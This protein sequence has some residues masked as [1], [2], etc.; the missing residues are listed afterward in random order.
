MV[1]CVVGPTASGKTGLAIGLAELFGGEVVSCDSMQIYRGMDIGTAKPTMS[2]RRGIPHH[3]LDIVEPSE[4]FSAARYAEE[5]SA[6]VD[7]IL[8]R[9]RLPVIAGG[10][11]LYLNALL[12]GLHPAAG[13]PELR[14]EIEAR[15]EIYAE[16][17][18]VDPAAAARLHPNDR[19]RIVR[20]LEVY[21]GSGETISERHEISRLEPPRYKSLTIGIKVER[22]ELYARI[23]ER[24]DKMLAEGLRDELKA[25]EERVPPPCHTAAQAIGYKEHGDAETIKMNT[26]RYAKRQM[27][28]FN[29]MP[30][31]HWV[32][33]ENILEQATR[34]AEKY[35]LHKV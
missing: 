31:V 6:C 24:V 1:L 28:W 16:L 3:M 14:R 23:D 12:Y 30:D 33:G 25:F 29:R 35:G 34:I 19:K 26:R 27:T 17:E 21:Y 8:S 10:T 22:G 11:G 18:R 7:G 20:A 32:E 13:H 15:E 5:A 4:P 2:E 9:G